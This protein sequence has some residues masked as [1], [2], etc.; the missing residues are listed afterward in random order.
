MSDAHQKSR[1]PNANSVSSSTGDGNSTSVTFRFE[2]NRDSGLRVDSAECAALLGL[3]G[4]WGRGSW[5]KFLNRIPSLDRHKLET[6]LS[7]LTPAAP[8]YRTSYRYRPS[9]GQALIVEECG[10]AEFDPEQRLMLRRG[11]IADVTAE[12]NAAEDLRRNEQRMRLALSA[13]REGGWSLNPATGE[14]AVSTEVRALLCLPTDA[15]TTLQAMLRQIHASDRLHLKA[16]LE[17][18]IRGLAPFQAEFR[19]TPPDGSI[20]WL[21]ARGVTYAEAGANLVL[22][23]L[24]QDISKYKSREESLLAADHRKDEFLAMLAHELRNPLAPVRNTAE[25]LRRI[26]SDNPRLRESSRMIARQC[27]HM[28]RLIEDLMDVTRIARGRLELRRET[29]Q[30]SDIL[31]Q[32]RELAGRRIS[33]R[34]QRLDFGSCP[35]SILLDCDPVRLC[36]V[37]ANLLENAAKYTQEGGEIRLKVQRLQTEV[38]VRISDNG[39]GLAP[40]ELP[41]LFDGLA[42]KRIRPAP[43]LAGLGL[44]LSIVKRLVNMHGGSVTAES[45]GIGFGSTFS[46]QLPLSE[47]TEPPAKLPRN[48]AP[49]RMLVVDDD[50]DIAHSTGLLLQS[51]GHEVD[52]AANAEEA[53]R[54]ASEQHHR[55][56]LLDIGLGTSDGLDVARRLRQL[57][58]GRKMHIVAVTG[59]GDSRTRREV[60]AA[61][62]NRHLLKPLS[63]DALK[64]LIGSLDP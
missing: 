10:W 26:D 22:L 55:L 19:I 57:P 40:D 39:L 1:R 46:V 34:R 54:C 18:S 61:G 11:V 4:A 6:T 41:H 52:L 35:D 2:W 47:R 31:A 27:A 42:R 50:A 14:C 53:L 29:S 48:S 3:E 44:G 20:R 33:E 62:I 59:H 58:H 45:P 56:V 15:P 43:P 8:T 60:R 32:A 5:Q 23:G 24:M 25:I 36:Q 64:A 63:P 17:A 16:C 13:A 7:D 37:F 30:L 12:R 38:L 9:S 28:E 49:L 51:L 21:S